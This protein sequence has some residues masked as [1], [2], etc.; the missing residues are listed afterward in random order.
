MISKVIHYCWFGENSLLELAKKYILSWKK[1]CPD[2]EIKEWNECNV[3]LRCCNF[4]NEA[5]RP[6]NGRLSVI[7]LD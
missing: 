6:K 2:Y 5:Y 7:L 3:D 1:Y 4:V